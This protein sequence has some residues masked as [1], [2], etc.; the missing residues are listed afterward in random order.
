MVEWMNN[1]DASKGINCAN[2]PVVQDLQFDIKVMKKESMTEFEGY[3]AGLVL[4]DE[5]IERSKVLNDKFATE[6]ERLKCIIE[7]NFNLTQQANSEADRL[8]QESERLKEALSVC[9]P[10]DY[11]HTQVGTCIFCGR[12]SEH[13]DDCEYFRL[14]GEGE[15]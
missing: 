7:L 8:E 11:S 14:C 5:E 15:K 6:I 10:F 9:D 1:F 3:Q 13:N 2:C 4:R 12:V